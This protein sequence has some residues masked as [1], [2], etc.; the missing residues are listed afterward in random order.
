M[1]SDDGV[2]LVEIRVHERAQRAQQTD[3]VPVLR[4]W[5]KLIC[6]KED[7]ERRGRLA[8]LMPDSGDAKAS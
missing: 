7:R 3:M 4:A 5:R 1:V 2:L 6:E 8:L